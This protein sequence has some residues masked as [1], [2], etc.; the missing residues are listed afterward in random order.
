[1]RRWSPVAAPAGHYGCCGALAALSRCGCRYRTTS[2]AGRS[3]IQSSAV[4]GYAVDRSVARVARPNARPNNKA[5]H[6][7]QVHGVTQCRACHK[8]AD[9]MLGPHCALCLPCLA[10]IEND[11]AA[12]S[13]NYSINR[14]CRPTCQILRSQDPGKC[15]CVS[16]SN[17]TTPAATLQAR[18]KRQPE[19]KRPSGTGL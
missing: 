11:A 14:H 1:V 5:L 12:T 9:Q 18:K 8:L 7:C 10:M 15:I 19:S 13:G 2:H 4:R 6:P 17:S 16:R 3:L